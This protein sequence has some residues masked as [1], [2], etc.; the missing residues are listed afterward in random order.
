VHGGG[1]AGT[2]QAYIPSQRLAPYRSLMES[3]FGLGGLGAVFPLRIR[4]YG[5]VCIENAK[6]ESDER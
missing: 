2:I 1:F 5:V 4:P 3:V 6:G